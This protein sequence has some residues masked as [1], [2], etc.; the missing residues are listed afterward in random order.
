MRGEPEPVR[1]EQG[2]RHQDGDDRPRVE[3]PPP[4]GGDRQ[5]RQRERR[6]EDEVRELRQGPERERHAE[7]GVAPRGGRGLEP[8]Q[9]VHGGRG[10]REHRDALGQVVVDEP[11]D[12]QEQEQRERGKPGEPRLGQDPPGRQVEE[13]VRDGE[14]RV[15]ERGEAGHADARQADRRPREPRV[16]RR[17]AGLVAPGERL[18]KNCF[19][20]VVD[21]KNWRDPD[22][23]RRVRDRVETEEEGKGAGPQRATVPIDRSTLPA[24]R[25]FRARP[26]VRRE[27]A[28]RSAVAP[29]ADRGDARRRSMTRTTDRL[30]PRPPASRCPRR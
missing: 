23:Q 24:P 26:R 27:R 28:S 2:D 9:R 25:R 19:P 20:R 16:E 22:S 18:A 7:P 3:E 17:L 1:Q 10:R 6:A 15:L 14:H 13:G 21:V 4:V 30:A 12:R 8:N 29:F 11:P 5:S